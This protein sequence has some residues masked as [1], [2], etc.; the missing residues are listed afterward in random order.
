MCF[1]DAT[2]LSLLLKQGQVG[3]YHLPT[4]RWTVKAV[5]NCVPSGIQKE[6]K[7][8]QFNL[9]KLADTLHSKHQIVLQIFNQIQ[10]QCS[11]YSLIGYQRHC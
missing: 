11:E 4:Q 5:F 3:H 10:G 2:C 9:L 7:S 8:L 1:H 6:V